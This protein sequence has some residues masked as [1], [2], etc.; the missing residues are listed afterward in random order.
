MHRVQCLR[1]LLV[2]QRQQVIIF[3]IEFKIQKYRRPPTNS[4]SLLVAKYMFFGKQK[5]DVKQLKM[6]KFTFNIKQLE[7]EQIYKVVFAIPY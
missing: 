6:N 1:N 4:R 5:L 2:P 7:N 3:L